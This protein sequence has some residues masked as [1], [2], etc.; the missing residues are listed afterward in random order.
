MLSIHWSSASQHVAVNEVGGALR[1]NRHSLAMLDYSEARFR[2]ISTRV[3]LL[4]LWRYLRYEFLVNR[5]RWF[6][7]F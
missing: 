7:R 6:R 3:K 2:E 1:P 5:S 4:S